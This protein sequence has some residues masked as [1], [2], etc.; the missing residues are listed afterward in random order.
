MAGSGRN[1]AGGYNNYRMAAREE[2]E[3]RKWKSRLVFFGV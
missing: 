1:S 3:K 2:K